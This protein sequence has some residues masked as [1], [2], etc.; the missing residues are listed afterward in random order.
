MSNSVTDLEIEDVLS[1]IRRL[2]TQ[3]DRGPVR[4]ASSADRGAD[5]LML[6]PAL[7]VGEQAE[8]E[9]HTAPLDLTAF[10]AR[11]AEGARDAVEELSA[12]ET[13]SDARGESDDDVEA[14][15]DLT[16]ENAV[17]D[18]PDTAAD[19]DALLSRLTAESPA[20]AEVEDEE[21]AP[22]LESNAAASIAALLGRVAETEDAF[23]AEPSPQAEED[24]LVEDAPLGLAEMPDA[25]EV[26][27]AEVASFAA[28]ERDSTGD[29]VEVDY[30]P[31]PSTRAHR[32]A[33][34]STIAEL[35]AAVTDEP[36]FE[37][38]GSERRPV[39]DWAEAEA[40]TASFFTS[41]LRRDAPAPA[42]PNSVDD[43]PDMAADD[44]APEAPMA[45]DVTE[46]E[47]LSDGGSASDAVTVGPWP[48]RDAE[49]TEEPVAEAEETALEITE[50]APMLPETRPVDPAPMS[51]AD[52]MPIDEDAIR[53]IV[54]EVLREELAG[55]LGTRITGNVRRLVRREVTR[56]LSPGGMAD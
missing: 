12:S 27:D 53:R 36:S 15:V 43:T 44:T 35:E 38:D 28:E 40:S 1:S 56:A 17:E 37:P 34:E 48:M 32:A 51:D 25:D 10:R 39:M 21:T 24:R 5:R 42:R 52:A 49:A 46:A 11:R 8:E 29:A 26:L 16:P 20:P 9:D 13:A 3:G 6:T 41:R 2:V 31:G 4:Q 47:A 55:E 23:E 54:A 22:Q 30:A 18:E 7:R 33:L 14:P 45:V 50:P 19:V